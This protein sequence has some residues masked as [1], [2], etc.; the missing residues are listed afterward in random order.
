MLASRNPNES[1]PNVE[2]LRKVR[3]APGCFSWDMIC[4][5]ARGGGTGG[6]TAEL[7]KLINGDGGWDGVIFFLGDT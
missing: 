4:H 2:F 3:K 7:A 1:S 6:A 5:E